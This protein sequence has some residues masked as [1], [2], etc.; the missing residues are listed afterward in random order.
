MIG[1]HQDDRARGQCVARARRDDRTREHEE[2]QCQFAAPPHQGLCLGRSGVDDRKVETGA[3][4]AGS[5]DDHDRARVAFCV[6]EGR[7]ERVDGG[8]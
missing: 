6:V 4:A 3:E 8:V 1:G 7:I 2:T 5:P